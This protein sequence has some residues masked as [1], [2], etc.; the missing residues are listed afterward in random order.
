MMNRYMSLSYSGYEEV[1]ECHNVDI[2]FKAWIAVH[3]TNL[4]PALGGCR[5]WKYQ[6]EEDALMD[7]GML[8]APDF[9]I[10]AG[11]VINISCEM[12]RRYSADEAQSITKGISN[13]LSDIFHQSARDQVPT[14]IVAN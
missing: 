1:V 11:G 10:N 8:Y 3:N 2:G 6:S 14:N 9:A 4:G 12:N 13:T 5:F 7:R